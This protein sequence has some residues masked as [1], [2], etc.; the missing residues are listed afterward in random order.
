MLRHHPLG[1]FFYNLRFIV[2]SASGISLLV[3]LL[4]GLSRTTDHAFWTVLISLIGIWVVGAVSTFLLHRSFR[5]TL[6]RWALEIGNDAFPEAFRRYFMLDSVLVIFVFS[7]GRLMP[8]QYRFD[9]FCWLLLA[10]TILYTGYDLRAIRRRHAIVLL[11]PIL[12]GIVLIFRDSSTALPSWM[13]GVV[14]IGPVVAACVLSVFAV[15]TI[16]RARRLES[17]RV[18]SYMSILGDVGKILAPPDLKSAKI[19]Q[20]TA[21]YRD[22][23][24]HEFRARLIIALRL[25]CTNEIFW[26]RSACLWLSEYH[27]D[28][29]EVLVPAAYFDM[30]AT[31]GSD[32]IDADTG[33]LDADSPVLVRSLRQATIGD[34]AETTR[35]RYRT[36][37]DVP[38]A[39][40]PID[41][42]GGRI[43][44]LVL[45]GQQFGVPVVAADSTFL[46]A[47]AATVARSLEQWD[48]F[49]RA[50][51]LDEL[52]A[53]FGCDSIDDLLQSADRLLK[54][55]LSARGCMIVFR[56]DPT[57]PDM[58]VQAVE[59]FQ[60]SMLNARYEAGIGLT[61]RCA[62]TGEVIR[63]DDVNHHR[64]EFDAPLFKRL[65]RSHGA[66]VRSWI[67]IPI[68][69]PARNYGVIKAVNST[70][71][72]RWFTAFD[73]QLASDMAVRLFVMI[74]KLLHLEEA[75]DAKRQAES[76]A[77]AAM[78]AKRAA[79]LTTLRRE[80]D[81]MTV[82]HQLQLPLLGI[83]NA[84]TA[85]DADTL[86][87]FDAD[88][89]VYAEQLVEDALA[90]GFGTLTVFAKEAG[91]QTMFQDIEIDA[92]F[93]LK[94]LAERLQRTQERGDLT[95][96]F[97][98]DP[99][100]PRLRMDSAVFASVFYSLLH[101]AMKYADPGSVVT[102]E[103]G[104]EGVSGLSVRW[105]ALKVKTV[106]EPIPPSERDDVFEKF[107]RG[108][109][110][111]HGKLY[112]GVGLGLWVA[113]GLMEM[114]GGRLTLELS[115]EHPERT[116]FVVQIPG[117]EHF[118]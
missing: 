43:G 47:L 100:F 84:L 22:Y 50:L 73:E 14:Q 44:T 51:A 27:Q 8:S 103:C 81:I 32:G 45:Y 36:Q 15:Y 101:N 114:L 92:G 48:T 12:V 58:H 35:W 94:G 56:P 55:Y 28:R 33:F 66:P 59:G 16:T 67:A 65:Q 106:G 31:D 96:H 20:R 93:E 74:E 21:D 109:S 41:G 91:K 102:L 5:H 112:R 40:V 38:A 63:I 87:E 68:G 29:G 52:D 105:P 77:T 57:M 37:D 113:R 82:M 1:M 89:V 117:S 30:P 46:K 53:L 60:P 10:N 39:I 110:V 76:N 49:L 13:S 17:I 80:Q 9:A 25:V 34:E 64:A 97:R 111:A 98:L 116:V 118:G 86:C 78:N 115:L 6:D 71:P 104:F 11:L 70:Y 7:Y 18:D 90:L 83:S 99:D 26:Y 3:C 79:E 72:C 95:F 24:E 62:A 61:G 4:G 54:R 107:V 85:I 69:R 23:R 88:M 2:F 19:V 75:E 42:N 108:S